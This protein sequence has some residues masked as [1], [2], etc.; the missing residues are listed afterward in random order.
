ME[1]DAEDLWAWQSEAMD[2]DELEELC[3]HARPV[4]EVVA[5]AR[6]LFAERMKRHIFGDRDE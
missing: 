5:E 3:N 2:D 6:R 1:D 4:E